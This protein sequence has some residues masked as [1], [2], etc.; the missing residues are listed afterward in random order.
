MIVSSR[1]PAENNQ[2]QQS[3]ATIPFSSMLR[4]S[5]LQIDVEVDE[6]E[7]SENPTQ[8]FEIYNII[9][10]RTQILDVIIHT[11]SAAKINTFILE[12]NINFVTR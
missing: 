1:A 5:L 3:W 12:I 11:C 6:P 10:R 9:W 8:S 4:F 7:T 2:G